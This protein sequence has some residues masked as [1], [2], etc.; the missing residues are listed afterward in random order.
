ME[1][2]DTLSDPFPS[3]QGERRELRHTRPSMTWPG[4]P[5]PLR[6]ALLP[7][8]PASD[9]EKSVASHE[10]LHRISVD[11]AT[12][13]GDSGS[14]LPAGK[15]HRE[16]LRIIR[17]LMRR[18][19]DRR[20][21]E[22]C[23]VVPLSG[24]ARALLPTIPSFVRARPRFPFCSVSASPAQHPDCRPRQDSSRRRFRRGTASRL[25]PLLAR[26]FPAPAGPFPPLAGFRRL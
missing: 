16:T 18:A 14:R 15:R 9:P 12:P 2:H 6:S 7:V 24:Y 4:D 20:R 26:G 21:R 10:S 13:F 1:T 25:H 11:Y 19:P 22:R 3:G 5:R 8:R 23:R 17:A